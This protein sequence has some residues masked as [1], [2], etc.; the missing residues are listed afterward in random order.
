MGE[1][2]ILAYFHGPDEAQKAKE[3]L[4]NQGYET[5]QVDNFSHFPG[6]ESAERYFNPLT[7]DE[8]RSL[9]SLIEG[10]ETGDDSRVMMAAMP[11][12]SGM[13]DN[14]SFISGRNYLVTVVCDES[15]YD[16]AKQLLSAHGGYTEA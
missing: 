7:G 14:A 5:V 10:V 12:A 2:T 3:Q 16:E 4:V 9:T 8:R 1:K 13:A 11:T 15:K 6:P